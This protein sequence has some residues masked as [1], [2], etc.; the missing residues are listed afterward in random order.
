M[1]YLKDGIYPAS[2]ARYVAV[3][4]TIRL[5]YLLHRSSC[6][7]TCVYRR[8]PPG[9]FQINSSRDPPVNFE[10]PDRMGGTSPV[11]RKA[12]S[13]GVSSKEKSNVRS[14][15]LGAE[16]PSY[17]PLQRNGVAG[18][19]LGQNEPALVTSTWGTGW[20]TPALMMANYCLGMKTSTKTYCMLMPRSI[21][22]CNRTFLSI[23]PYQWTRRRWA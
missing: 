20:R 8:A 13:A 15:A 6:G 11:S 16:N 14:I 19:S 18:A 3:S 1:S 7:K 23:P 5:V 22:N 21:W 9:H 4:P 12:M 10:T 2:V 17:A